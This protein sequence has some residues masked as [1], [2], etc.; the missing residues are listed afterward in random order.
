L[1]KP[2]KISVSL[3]KE[4]SVIACIISFPKFPD[5]SFIEFIVGCI[6]LGSTAPKIAIVAKVKAFS[7]L[8]VLSRLMESFIKGVSITLKGVSK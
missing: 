2:F 6:L 3:G 4:C 8:A 1:K 5:S 7:N